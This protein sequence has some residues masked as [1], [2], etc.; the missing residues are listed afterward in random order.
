MTPA[1]GQFDGLQGVHEVNSPGEW[2]W[3]N[4]RPGQYTIQLLGICRT[5]IGQNFF[6][7]I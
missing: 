6:I 5:L 3:V 7:L 1:G 4:E 2:F